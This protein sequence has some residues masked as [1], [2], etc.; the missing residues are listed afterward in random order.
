M[1]KEMDVGFGAD[2]WV[3]ATGVWERAR[4]ELD[5][6]CKVVDRSTLTR[7]VNM[8]GAHKGR[9]LTAGVGTSAAV[10]RKIAHTLSCIECPAFF[11]SPADAVHGALGSVQPGD[12]AILISKGGNTSEIIA[13]LP[14]LNTRNVAIIAVTEN[15]RSVLA[16]HASVVLQI[17]VE[18][19]ADEFNMLATTSSM[20]VTA[21]FDAICV[22][23][24][25]QN[26]FTREQ[27][28]VIH[29][30]G[31]VGSRLNKQPG[32]YDDE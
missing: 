27:F 22:A 18:R 3:I 20:V 2:P 25:R 14:A 28:A 26:G 23:V 13:L 21:L 31:A 7:V 4:N 12:L 5:R 8:I 30:G 10:A 11:L 17:A 1:D 6:L 32:A 19:E 15:K 9:I 24:M 29:P 16:K